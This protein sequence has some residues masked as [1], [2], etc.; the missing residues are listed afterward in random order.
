MEGCGGESA[1]EAPRF[2]SPGPVPPRWR[3]QVSVEVWGRR[4]VLRLLRQ[5]GEQVH[6]R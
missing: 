2:A 6:D 3:A 1:A 4:P 5:R